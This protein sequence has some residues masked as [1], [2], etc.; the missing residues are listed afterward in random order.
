MQIVD[1]STLR[2]LRES[3]A[4]FCKAITLATGNEPSTRWW[5]DIAELGWLAV[6]TAEDQGGS[7][8]GLAGAGV[9]AHELGKAGYARGYGE[10][11]ALTH[12]LRRGLANGDIASSAAIEKALEETLTGK[13][14]ISLLYP[15]GPNAANEGLVP[16]VGAMHLLV[17]TLGADQSLSLHQ[18][19]DVTRQQLIKT[20][21][22]SRDVLV[23][24]HQQSFGN[25]SVRISLGEGGG[26]QRVWND[27]MET[28]RM[29]AAAQLVGVAQTALSMALD[30]ANIRSQ[31]GRLIGAY[32]AVQHAI[33]DILAC[34]DA[35]ELLVNHALAA[36]DARRPDYLSLLHAATAFAR[37]A[38]WTSL[39]KTYD[40]LGGVGFIEVHPI[41]R[42][43]RAMMLTLSSLGS[44]SE[45]EDAAANH[46]C[47]GHWLA[48]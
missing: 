1:E 8:L 44:A 12:A 10:T 18:L 47:P 13:Q 25:G 28:H 7:G 15:L 46:V 9:I 48:I 41:N 6:A 40:V 20:T 32:Q 37:E 36:F 42:Y 31:F 5:S 17:L 22:R 45:C 4:D 2:L 16:D 39:M 30:Y 19:T 35:A 27:A 43:T 38:A 21:S 26:A 23:E 33:V 29:L 3:A 24:L 14:Q 34:T 11:V